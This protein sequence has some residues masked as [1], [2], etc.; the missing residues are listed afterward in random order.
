M[1]HG[2]R[3]SFLVHVDAEEWDSLQAAL[4]IARITLHTEDS[5]YAALDSAVRALAQADEVD[6]DRSTL[7]FV[8]LPKPAPIP[9]KPTHED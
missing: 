4:A 7:V 3:K 8:Q 6:M 2:H 1:S 9:F 5:Y